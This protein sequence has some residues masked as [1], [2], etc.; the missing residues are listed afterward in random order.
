MRVMRD[1]SPWFFVLGW[2]ANRSLCDALTSYC[3]AH[4]AGFQGDC[5][6]AAPLESLA[7]EEGE[8]PS[9]AFPGGAC[10]RDRSRS[11][12]RKKTWRTW[13][14][15]RRGL[16]LKNLQGPL[17]SATWRTSLANLAEQ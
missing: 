5:A 15:S 12:M 7:D 3:L 4:A 9:R 13:R 16:L 6:K 8:P 14:T 11:G 10:E 17:W 2:R 1:L